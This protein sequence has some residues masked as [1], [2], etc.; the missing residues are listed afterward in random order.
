MTP[1]IACPVL[2]V[3]DD[4]HARR[5]LEHALA[6]HG[7]APT[8]VPDA[9]TA[10]RLLQVAPSPFAL[11]LCDL[12][13]P[14]E[15]GIDLVAEI[16]NNHPDTAVLII[17]AE[18]D[19]TVAS[20]ASALG[21]YGYLVKPFGL[22]QLLLSVAATL[23]RHQLERQRDARADQLERAVRER[24]RELEHA[25]QQTVRTLALAAEFR[26]R[27]TQQHASRVGRYSA[28]IAAQIGCD[29]DYCKLIES[30]ALLHDVGKIG[31]PDSILSKRGPLT[32]DERRIMQTHT[33]IGY[34]LLRGSGDEL[35]ELAATIALTHHE[36]LDGSGYPRGLRSQE[37]PVEGQIVAVA[38]VFDALTSDRSYRPAYPVAEAAEILRAATPSQLSEHMVAALVD[39]GP[40]A[41]RR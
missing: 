40:R 41:N 5:L 22:D 38:D 8:A 3:D 17:S 37:I 18:H 14:D 26:D 36:R 29:P 19:P 15:R 24:T 23:R 32:A 33:D 6:V 10:R 31:V 2:I 16:S 13:L 1:S 25:R 35:L 28:L 4:E 34:R 20:Q 39:L 11:A 30:A 9:A 12:G 27:T 7:Y 21:A